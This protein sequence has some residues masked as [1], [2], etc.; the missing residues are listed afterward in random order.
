MSQ[1]NVELHRRGYDAWNRHDLDAWLAVAD[2][3]VEFIPYTMEME[4]GGRLR[5]HDGARRLW[6]SQGEAFPDRRLEVDEIRELGDTTFAAVRFRGHGAGSEIPI[7][8]RVWHVMR[9]RNGKCVRWQA[10]R[11]EA[12]ALKAAGLSE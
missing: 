6:E 5:G 9:W 2:P 4:G 8:L 3:S 10:F 7:V 1:E 11:T 12:E